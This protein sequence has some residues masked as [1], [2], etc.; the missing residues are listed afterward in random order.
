MRHWQKRM[1]QTWLPYFL[2]GHRVAHPHHGTHTHTL[3][4]SA[5]AT[6]F[7]SDLWLNPV[8]P[9]MRILV[10]KKK[11]RGRGA[12]EI[13]HD[14]FGRQAVPPSQS[15]LWSLPPM[16]SERGVLHNE[17]NHCL[18][19]KHWWQPERLRHGDRSW[20]NVGLKVC[21]HQETRQ[22]RSTAPWEARAKWSW[23]AQWTSF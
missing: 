14:T 20:K 6:S 4:K 22:S 9:I 19:A 21:L 5:G 2:I 13:G 10:N 23:D 16:F 15:L 17:S 18:S 8:S 7:L 3:T 1:T 12:P 11:K